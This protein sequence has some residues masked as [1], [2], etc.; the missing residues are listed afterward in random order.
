MR[1]KRR[2]EQFSDE[3]QAGILRD[4]GQSKKCD[5]GDLAI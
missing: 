3:A 5:A 4:D 1:V 2:A